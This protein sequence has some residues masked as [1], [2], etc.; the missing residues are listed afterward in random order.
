MRT[1]FRL[2]LLPLTFLIPPTASLAGLESMLFA[3]VS[4][5]RTAMPDQPEFHSANR[6]SLQQLA[7]FF[8]AA[9]EG[10]PYPAAI[11]AEQLAKRVR[12][13]SIDLSLSSVMTQRG[14][15]IGVFLLARRGQ[16]A[17]CGGFGVNKPQ[18][19]LG[20]S[21][22]LCAEMFA[23]ARGSG[24]KRFYLEVLKNNTSAVRVYEKAGLRRLREFLIL[25]WKAPKVAPAIIDLPVPES[26]DPQEIL[27]EYPQ[28]HVGRACWQRNYASLLARSDLTALRLPGAGKPDAYVLTV[29]RPDGSLRLMDLGTR[30]TEALGC[31]LEAVK[32]AYPGIVITNE[33]EDSPHL[34]ALLAAGIVETDRQYE[35]LIEL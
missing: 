6:H 27:A 32:Q 14:Y 1:G 3:A 13:E 19:G 9:F 10:Y 22:A 12:E 8:S 30:S 15:P 34:P 29:N 31:L 23:Q 33:A 21:H 26:F 7:A 35:M 16:E 5:H 17:W 25:G 28:W 2:T 18:R 4:K 24:A 11:A 20:F